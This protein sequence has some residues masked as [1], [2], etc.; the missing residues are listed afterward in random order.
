[1]VAQFGMGKH[2]YNVTI[3]EESYV[4]KESQ[5]LSKRM[6]DDMMEIVNLGY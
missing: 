6:D 1:M 2:S 4:R 3:D 5:F